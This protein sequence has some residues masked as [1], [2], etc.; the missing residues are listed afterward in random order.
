VTISG[1][2]DI[3]QSVVTDEFG[4][5]AEAE[6]LFD[7]AI[8]GTLIFSHS[9][10]VLSIGRNSSDRLER[11]RLLSETITLQFN[12]EYRIAIGLGARST[13]ANEIPEPATLFL[14]VS[15]LGFVAGVVKTRRNRV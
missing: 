13:A 8:N 12:T 1:I 11:T 3:V 14:L 4:V 2:L 6:A 9:G 7:L 5:M 15:G 10:P